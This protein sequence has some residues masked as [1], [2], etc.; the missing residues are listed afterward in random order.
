MADLTGTAKCTE[1]QEICLLADSKRV[2]LMDLEGIFSKMVLTT[3]ESSR[4][5]LPKPPKAISTRTIWNTEEVLRTIPSTDTVSR[6]EESMSSMELTAMVKKLKEF[7]NGIPCPIMILMSISMR[8]SLT[9]K[10]SSMEKVF[11]LFNSGKL[12]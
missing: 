6:R 8:V 11:C 1:N 7:S 5:I 10:G 3:M 12:K 2:R 9:T 4:T